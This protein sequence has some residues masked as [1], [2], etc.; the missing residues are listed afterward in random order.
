MRKLFSSLD[1]E[2]AVIAGAV[3]KQADM[4]R[5]TARR[6]HALPGSHAQLLAVITFAAVLLMA[7]LP[8]Q[9]RLAGQAPLR[10][11]RWRAP[12]QIGIGYFG[13]TFGSFILMGSL[14]G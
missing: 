10:R 5:F 7:V 11:K 4:Q 12:R 2:I 13:H 14:I 6:L 8:D 1:I 3:K 9:Q